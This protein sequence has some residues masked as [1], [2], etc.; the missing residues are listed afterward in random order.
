M[1]VDK[2]KIEE[3]ANPKKRHFWTIEY[4]IIN[5]KNYFLKINRIL[6]CDLTIN[7][8]RM[9]YFILFLFFLK[10]FRN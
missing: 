10:G 3:E 8:G 6:I 9:I 2:L 1:D 5:L 7:A 4:R